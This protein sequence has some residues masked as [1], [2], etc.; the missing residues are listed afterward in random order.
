MNTKL[1]LFFLMIFIVSIETSFAQGFMAVANVSNLKGSAFGNREAL[2]VGT[3]IIEGMEIYIPKK[4]ESLD[5]KFQN[6]HLFRLIG[7]QVKVIK[8]NP[9]NAVFEIT[10]GKIYSSIKPLSQNET[11][12]FKTKL[13]SFS[14]NASQFLIDEDKKQTYLYVSEG[15]VLV[16]AG[17]NSVKA[18]KDEDVLIAP[19]RDLKASLAT[20]AMSAQTKEIINQLK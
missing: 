6:G 20:K 2:K 13:A 17:K 11:F 4:M 10:K 3:E 16:K 19:G 7:A 9:K 18:V 15:S 8:L 12:D 5:I 1:S 14:A